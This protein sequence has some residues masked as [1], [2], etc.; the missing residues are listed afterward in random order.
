MLAV[1]GLVVHRDALP[2]SA[3]AP[4]PV[5]HA[6][7]AATAAGEASKMRQLYLLQLGATIQHPHIHVTEKAFIAQGNGILD[8]D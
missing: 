4:V 5:Y 1:L 7:P 3:A 2:G 8:V 6:V